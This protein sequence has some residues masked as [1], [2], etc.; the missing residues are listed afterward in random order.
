M[1]DFRVSSHAHF[2]EACRKF[3]ATHNVK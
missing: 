1:L 3:A 2:D